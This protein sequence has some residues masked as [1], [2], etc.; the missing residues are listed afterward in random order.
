MVPPA[1]GKANTAPDGAAGRARTTGAKPASASPAPTQAA[2][3]KPARPASN[4]QKLFA[5][6]EK[7]IGNLE[8]AISFLQS[9][10]LIPEGNEAVT[11]QALITGLLHFAVAAPAAEL[12]RSGCTGPQLLA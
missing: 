11:E 2:K 7:H 5:E 4:Q 12:A 1:S 6:A 9:R 10:Q 3:K 8:A